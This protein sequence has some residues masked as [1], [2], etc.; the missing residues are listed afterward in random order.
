MKRRRRKTVKLPKGIDSKLELDL[1]NGPLAACSW[2]PDPIDY[3]IRKK[4][5]P[6]CQYGNVII[7][8]K[9]RFRTSEE[10]R[11][12]VWVRKHLQEGQELVFVFSN[13]K[14]KMPN[15]KKRKDGTYHTHAEWADKNNFVYYDAK[16]VPTSWGKVPKK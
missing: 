6:D 15:A 11:K 10:A 12:Y 3:I 16:C 2:K 1:K 4:Y 9:G 7:E 8:I 14:C 5:N 13:P